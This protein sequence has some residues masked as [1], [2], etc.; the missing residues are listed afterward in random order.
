M[1]KFKGINATLKKL[2]KGRWLAQ[3]TGMTQHMLLTSSFLKGGTLSLE[4]EEGN[5][6]TAM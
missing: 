6:T 2:V 4:I 1:V 5:E 3:H